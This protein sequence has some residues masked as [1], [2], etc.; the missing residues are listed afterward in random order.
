MKLYA[1]MT[2]YAFQ[3]ACRSVDRLVIQ[4]WNGFVSVLVKKKKSSGEIWNNFVYPLDE[5]GYPEVPVHR[6][7]EEVRTAL[8]DPCQVLMMQTQ[9]DETQ[10]ANH[11]WF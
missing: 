5:I 8:Q 11:N 6:Y 10:T 7:G 4:P 1:L 2:Q 3:R 9:C